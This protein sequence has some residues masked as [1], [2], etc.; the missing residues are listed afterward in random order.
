M[1]TAMATRPPRRA[2]PR[3]GWSGAAEMRYPIG[4]EETLGEALNLLPT[5]RSSRDDLTNELVSLAARYG[6]YW[7]QDEN[8]PTRAEQMGGMVGPP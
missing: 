7:H 8:G 4:L 2:Q 5:V 6:H 1:S 3:W